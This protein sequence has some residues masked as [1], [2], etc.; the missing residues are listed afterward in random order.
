M[1]DDFLGVLPRHE[2]ETDEALILRA[3]IDAERFD[4]LLHTLG[5]P[6]APE[7]DQAPAFTTV[8]LRIEYF[9][10]EQ[11]Y[12][13]PA[14]KWQKLRRFMQDKLMTENKNEVRTS[15]DAAD[16]LSALGKFHHFTL[17]LTAGRPS[18]YALWLLLFT[19]SFSDKTQLKLAPK[20]QQ[21]K[22]TPEAAE[23]LFFWWEAVTTLPAPRRL[24]LPYTRRYHAVTLDIFLI[25]QLPKT[26]HPLWVVVPCCWWRRPMAILGEIGKPKNGDSAEKICIFLETL[27][28]GLEVM[29]IP[30]AAEAIVVRTNIGKLAEAIDKNLYV[31]SLEGAKISNSIHSLLA[32]RDQSPPKANPCPLELRS[33]LV[34]GGT[35]H[36]LD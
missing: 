16:L 10:K 17:V 36:P 33:V 24:M 21:L 35:P 13:V 1:L 27:Q 3:Q 8:W 22:T 29:D 19:A 4:T 23:T 14:E 31:K 20:K 26:K 32:S 25:K 2:E 15:L 9:S 34:K 28:E 11:C 30:T 7:K 6:K 18:L 5:L 12:G